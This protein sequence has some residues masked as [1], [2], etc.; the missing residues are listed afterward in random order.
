[1]EE[2][3]LKAQKIAA[4]SEMA[5]LINPNEKPPDFIINLIT[6]DTFL[7]LKDVYNFFSKIIS[8]DNL[9]SMEYA[10][11]LAINKN[12]IDNPNHLDYIEYISKIDNKKRIKTIATLIKIKEFLKLEN[13]F[14]ILDSLL[15]LEEDYQTVSAGYLYLNKGKI[16]EENFEYILNKVSKA[17]KDYVAEF[18]CKFV[19]KYDDKIVPNYLEIIDVVSK[20]DMEKDEFNLIA[21]LFDEFSDFFSKR[22]DLLEI[23][24]ILFNKN[25]YFYKDLQDSDSFMQKISDI[26][27]YIKD[28]I[29]EE[30]EYKNASVIPEHTY[31]KQYTKLLKLIVGLNT[32]RYWNYPEERGGYSLVNT[33]MILQLVRNKDLYKYN[34][35]YDI[36]K[37]VASMKE[38][39]GKAVELLEESFNNLNI[40]RQITTRVKLKRLKNKV[41]KG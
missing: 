32:K 22:E 2:S 39:S 30:E 8:S 10:S 7:G 4:L 38:K 23:T 35:W 5:K 15:N 25:M 40:G 12:L 11:K 28:T 6:N 41:N 26:K 37:T 3:I 36:L 17:E 16:N 13:S 24:K 33:T 19:V 14:D 20:S 21:A 27:Q 18:I 31:I 1:M 29:K 9:F 34:N